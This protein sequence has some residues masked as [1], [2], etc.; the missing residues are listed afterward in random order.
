MEATREIRKGLHLLQSL[1]PRELSSFDL[2]DGFLKH[3]TYEDIYV[4]PD[5]NSVSRKGFFPGR[6]CQKQL[7]AIV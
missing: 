2:S 7:E 4:C 6:I 5:G 3:P 1:I